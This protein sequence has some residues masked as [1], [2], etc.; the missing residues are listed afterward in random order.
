MIATPVDDFIAGAGDGV[1]SADR[2]L[3]IGILFSLTGLVIAAGVVAFVLLVARTGDGVSP[4]WQRVVAGGGAIGV[5]G[6]A[7]EVAGVARL[8]DVGWFEA[9]TV[10]QSGG[11]LLRL[12]GGVLLIIGLALGRSPGVLIAGS[13]AG[14]FSFAFDGHTVSRGP[15]P[16]HAAVNVAHASA[17]AIW[18]GGVICLA[19]I[20]A[21]SGSAA[22]ARSAIRFSPV[23]TAALVAVSVAGGAMSLMVVDGVSDYVDTT[24]GRILLLKLAAV[25]VAVGFGAYHHFRLVPKL[26]VDPAD[27]AA[28]T[29]ARRSM[30]IEA[31][32]LV[33]VVVVTAL[34][35]RATV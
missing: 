14:V 22:F 6:A 33:A 7:I 28:L 12:I 15:R 17:G 10:E 4:F 32:V 35:T 34:L 5:V 25:G 3:Q 24:W 29:T 26:E 18:V 13:L 2:L 9:L 11:P 20:A 31:V 16:V 27:A 23:A 19:V 8:S 21:R 30:T 1:E